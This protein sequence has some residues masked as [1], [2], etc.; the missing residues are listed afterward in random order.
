MARVIS[1]S[2]DVYELLKSLKREG[3]SFSEVIRKLARKTSIS[4]FSGI[5]SKEAADEIENAIEEL[6]W[7]MKSEMRRF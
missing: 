4:T 2:D 5:L 6:N 1:I 7:R 3:E